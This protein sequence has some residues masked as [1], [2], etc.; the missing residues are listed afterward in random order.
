[1]SAGAVTAT[2]ISV[3]DLS[4]ISANLGTIT[5]GSISAVTGSFH[6]DVRLDI[7]GGSATNKIDF[8]EE[9]VSFGYLSGDINSVVA[10]IVEDDV[11]TVLVGRDDLTGLRVHPNDGA[12]V[13]DA[14]LAAMDIFIAAGGDIDIDAVGDLV[15]EASGDIDFHTTTNAS[16]GSLVG[17]L[18]LKINGT[19]RKIPY[20]A[21]S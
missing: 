13:F 6:G 7:T 4:A 10:L 21:V 14:T 3:S 16:A 8:K 19:A 11:G 12:G 18:E 5:A 17:Y 1:M 20:H 2:K 9:G 15:L